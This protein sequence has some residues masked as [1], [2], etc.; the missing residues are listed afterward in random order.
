MRDVIAM[1]L[2]LAGAGALAAVPAR[3]DAPAAAALEGSFA[4]DWLKPKKSRCTKVE[5]ALLATLKKGYACAPADSGSASG[6]PILLTCRAKRGKSE[7][8]LFSTAAACAEE[9]ETQLANGD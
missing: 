9:R 8:M 5:G 7:Y 4:F 6:K 1:C 3:A 2:L